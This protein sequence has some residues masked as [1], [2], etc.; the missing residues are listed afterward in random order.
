M[1][2]STAACDAWPYL[3]LAQLSDVIYVYKFALHERRL[4][5]RRIRATWT[6]MCG[7]WKAWLRT[8]A[9]AM[10]PSRAL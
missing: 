6:G 3:L 4:L 7:R 9:G 5:P 10:T 2:F 8:C 1:V